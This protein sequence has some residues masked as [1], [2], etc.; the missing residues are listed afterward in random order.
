MDYMSQAL[1]IY[2]EQSEYLLQALS[3]NKYGTQI[4]AV[5]MQK[6]LSDPLEYLLF[7]NHLLVSGSMELIDQL[8]EF[9]YAQGLNGQQCSLA[10]LPLATQRTL[11]QA[12]QLSHSDDENIEI[13]LRDDVQ[14]VN[15]LQCNDKLF[16]FKAVIGE[17]P[18]LEGWHSDTSI[19]AFFENMLLGLRQFFRL[20]KNKIHIETRH[21][22]QINTVA[23][24]IFVVNQN[25]GSRLTQ[26]I[27]QRSS[28][29]SDM[30]SMMIV[31]PF[32]AIE[33]FL[34]LFS[35]IF[36]INKNSEKSLPHAVANIQSNEIV[37]DCESLNN[38][39]PK[40][41]LDGLKR[42]DFPLRFKVLKNVLKINA[43]E[44][45]W[46]L[47]PL[48]N[49]DKE[50]IRTDNLPDEKELDKYINKKLPFF[51]VA[52]EE[53]FKELFLQLRDDAHINSLY[54]IL[55]LLSTV[56]ASLGL[57]ANSSAVV[58]GAMLLAPLMSPIISSSM[59][60]LRGEDRLFYQSL[61]KLG[62]GIV[63][64]LLASFLVSLLMPQ[65]ELSS[66]ITA[67]IHPNLIDLAIAI[68][69]GIAAAYTK[70][71][72]ELLGNLAGVAIAVALVP[73]LASAGI[74]L[75]RG[76]L[77]VFEGALLLFVTN[78]VGIMLAATLTFQFLGF[79]ST[80]KRKKSL[81]L[82]VLTLI[83]L[84][85][86]LY[87]TYND[88]LQ[89]YYLTRALE[90]EQ[91]TINNKKVLIDKVV[92]D[93]QNKQRIIN[94]TLAVKQTLK[95]EDLYW[96]KQEITQRF[97]SHDQLHGQLRVSIKYIL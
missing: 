71:H 13:A 3:A 96:L 74:G 29:R 89:R 41:T 48:V 86:P 69:S 19:I 91:L 18:L 97:S 61:K 94:I 14:A 39:Q 79:S 75:G 85:Y 82:I 70:A 63:L 24:G 44:K 50:V 72:K 22:K 30:L 21:G 6:F 12:Y 65:T 59:G 68:F 37:L 51:S 73:P 67:R 54:L 77:Y 57:Y 15:L 31:S 25:R 55:L 32:S 46:E 33:Y 16:Q 40:I 43:S 5:K 81:T 4:K 53:R 64:A 80:V 23:N 92:I 76:E 47:N 7:S 34:F 36:N 27:Q 88:S 95:A 26:V 56:L 83:V 11:R 66:E 93:Y 35:L 84:S 58:I 60:L 1:F 90:N 2:D 17:I 87:R 28:M 78:L 38:T 8:L 42:S 9:S 52:S 10:F 62:L 45:F 49:S 20:K